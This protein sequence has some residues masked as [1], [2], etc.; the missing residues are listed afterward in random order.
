MFGICC[1]NGRPSSNGSRG[2]GKLTPEINLLLFVLLVLIYDYRF[3]LVDAAGSATSGSSGLQNL[4]EQNTKMGRDSS[5]NDFE[6]R[7]YDLKKCKG[8]GCP[9]T[10]SWLAHI[11]LY[12]RVGWYL[13]STKMETAS[14]NMYV[15]YN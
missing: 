10:A 15:N 11:N 14:F 1:I 13:E 9:Y 4:T 3:T 12:K 8:A 5:T 7:I 2:R 6:E